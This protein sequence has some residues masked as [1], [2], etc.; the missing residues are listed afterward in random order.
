M[1]V[2]LVD[3]QMV[4]HLQHVLGHLRAVLGRVV[5][6]FALAVAAA[7]DGHDAMVL[8]QR[9]GH[10][11]GEP[12]AFGAA[13]VAVNEHDRRALAGF[14]I[15]DLHAVGGGERAVLRFDGRPRPTAHAESQ[16]RLADRWS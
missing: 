8:G 16:D 14:E 11:V 3:L 1:H 6:L 4:H 15:V 9:F 12:I 2:G 5:R 7:V 13:G 10:A